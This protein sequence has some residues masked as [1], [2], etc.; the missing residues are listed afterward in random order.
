[1]AVSSGLARGLCDCVAPV[2]LGWTQFQQIIDPTSVLATAAKT[3]QYNKR[4]GAAIRA[5]RE[6]RGLKQTDIQGITVRQLRRV[7][8]EQQAAS[9]GTLAALAAA[10]S[11]SLE[12]YVDRLAK[13]VRWIR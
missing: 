9:K 8:Q 3:E 4:F 1:M 7:V 2:H 5:I 6:A 13:T 12:E 10:H 11:L